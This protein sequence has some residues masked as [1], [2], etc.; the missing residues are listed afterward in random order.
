MSEEPNTT[1][2]DGVA[3]SPYQDHLLNRVANVQQEKGILRLE[4]LHLITNPDP[5]RESVV[6]PRLQEVKE[7]LAKLRGQLVA[8]KTTPPGS[9]RIS[10]DQL[11]DS[12]FLYLNSLQEG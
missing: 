3:S 5:Q 1:P 7:D 4:Q 2:A 9:E 6:V 8:L 12:W 11:M 10:P